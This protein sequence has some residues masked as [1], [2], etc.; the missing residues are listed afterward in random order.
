MK[1]SYEYL[2]YDHDT[3]VNGIMSVTSLLRYAQQTASLQHLN[4]GPQIPDLRRDG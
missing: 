2:L 4:F 1:F 3:D